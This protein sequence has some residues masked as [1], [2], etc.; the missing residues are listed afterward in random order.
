MTVRVTLDEEGRSTCRASF[1]KD[2]NIVIESGKPEGVALRGSSDKVIVRI[3][4][5]PVMT[6]KSFE[7]EYDKILSENQQLKQMEQFIPNL[8]ENILDPNAPGY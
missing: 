1:L 2:K 7:E 8:K 4:D 5:V 6:I 3:G